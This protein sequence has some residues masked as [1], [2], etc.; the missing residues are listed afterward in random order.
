[1]KCRN[2][3]NVNESQALGEPLGSVK[4]GSKKWGW[5]DFFALGWTNGGRERTKELN[6]ADFERFLT[7]AD[8][9]DRMFDWVHVMQRV[10]TDESGLRQVWCLRHGL[11][12]QLWHES[13]WRSVAWRI[14]DVSSCHW[15]RQCPIS[16]ISGKAKMLLEKWST[17]SWFVLHPHLTGVL[18][19]LRR[20]RKLQF[21]TQDFLIGVP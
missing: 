21:V 5:G 2:H 1:M 12:P 18:C 15:N 3:V 16:I 4:R 17:K 19:Y 9:V 10:G 13:L 14:V 11:Q 20:T 6:C 8:V 7:L